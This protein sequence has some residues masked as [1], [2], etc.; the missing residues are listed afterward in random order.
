MNIERT[1]RRAAELTQQL[2][3]FARKKSPKVTVFDLNS[4][5]TNNKEMLERLAGEQIE[6]ST[7]L[8]TDPVQVRADEADIERA[9]VNLVINARDAM[10]SGGTLRIQTSIKRLHESGIWPNCEPG[11]YV[12][13]SVVDDG[14]GMPPEVI[15]RIFEPFFTTKMV[16]K[17]T[18]LGLSTVFMDIT[19]SGGFIT[20]ESRVG[21]G[22][23][24]HI[25]LPHAA[26]LDDPAVGGAENAGHAVGGNETILV[27]DD[28][29]FV[30]DAV[31]L[32]IENL[33][34]SVVRASSPAEAIAV[35]TSHENPISLLLTDVTMPGMNGV[36]LGKEITKIYPDMKVVL[37]SGYGEDVL[38]GS[39]SDG[40][41]FGFI[42]KPA[43]RDV[44]ARS[45]REVLDTGKTPE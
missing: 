6:L 7:Q 34:Y 17:G 26:V 22:T 43:P 39:H 33:G 21:E 27:C 30:L 29:D 28:E 11:T 36:E 3:A 37:M 32:V 12:R 18:G 40:Q 15:D 10:P 31:S 38:R 44:L 25:H 24:I 16:G 4:V 20:V 5:V 13:L 23:A 19:N 42:Q 9:I 14:C 41:Q 45:L 35:A 1:G 8:S 2:L